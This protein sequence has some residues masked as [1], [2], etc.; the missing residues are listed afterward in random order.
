ML[1][2][3]RIVLIKF[4][5]KAI[6]TFLHFLDAKRISMTLLF[7][8]NALFL[9]FLLC[10]TLLVGANCCDFVHGNPLL[11]AKIQIVD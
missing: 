10:I 3:R 11:Y 1:N 5:E 7:I 6:T 9:L 2:R 4:P 8:A